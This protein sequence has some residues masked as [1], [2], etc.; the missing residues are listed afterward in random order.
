MG[1][2]TSDPA[3]AGFGGA[4]LV[5]VGPAYA[6]LGLGL[7]L[8]F[9]AQGRGRTAQPLLATLTRLLVA[10]ALG[11]LATARLRLGDRRPF[12]PDGLRPRALRACDGRCHAPRTLV[13]RRREAMK[14]GKM[15]TTTLLDAYLSGPGILGAAVTGVSREQ[16]VLR[17]VAGR[18]S[19]L[20]VVCHLADTDANIAHRIK[21]VLSEER[22]VFDRVKP[23]LMLAA[24][25]YHDRDVEEELRVFD[26]TRRQI[27]RILRA[28]PP[29]AWERTGIVGDRGNRTVSQMI[30]GCG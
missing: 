29:E 21:R 6:F 30:N 16:L 13:L 1:L 2:F 11:V 26:L 12:R 17:P 3:V 18:W 23:D 9:A 22:P 27:G 8:Y 4:Y 5:R 7:A 10:G 24:L 19:V 20:E 14:P 15:E 28:S 25:A